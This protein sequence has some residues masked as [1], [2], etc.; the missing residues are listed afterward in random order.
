MPQRL[1]PG[2][3]QHPTTVRPEAPHVAWGWC[4]CLRFI[5]AAR[6]PTHVMAAGS[7]CMP[8]PVTRPRMCPRAPCLRPHDDAPPGT[9]A[10]RPRCQAL[11]QYA[12]AARHCGDTPMLPAACR[13]IEGLV[14]RLLNSTDRAVQSL[15]NNAIFYI[16]RQSCADRTPVVVCLPASSLPSSVLPA[17]W[18]SAWRK[19]GGGNP[20][21][22]LGPH[23]CKLRGASCNKSS[24]K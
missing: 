4:P 8:W 12:C 17:L 21:S 7:R 24:I 1:H 23:F 5:G 9:V 3:P 10:T 15:L 22:S 11:W 6:G 2:R 19:G 16:V 14:A 18:L 20:C 13:Y